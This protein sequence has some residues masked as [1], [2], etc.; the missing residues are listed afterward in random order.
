[1]RILRSTYFGLINRLA[2]LFLFLIF[3]PFAIAS[4][5]ETTTIIERGPHHR[6]IQ[7]THSAFTA[8]GEKVIETGQYTEVA[9]GLHYLENGQWVESQ[10]TVEPDPKVP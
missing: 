2:V 4:P 10:E 9:S 3:C 7:T 5:P 8:S 6:V 1:M